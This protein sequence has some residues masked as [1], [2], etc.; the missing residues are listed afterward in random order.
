MTQATEKGSS[1]WLGVIPLG[2]QGFTLN[3]WEFRDAIS[4]RYN[5]PKPDLPANCPCGQR[6][7][8]THALNCKRGGFVIMRHNNV[9]DFEANLL[10]KV[11]NDVEVEPPLQPLSGEATTGLTGD[12]ARPDIR[13]KGF[14]RQCQNAFFDIRVTNANSSS[15]MTL[16]SKQLY[17]RH[18]NE[19]IRAYNDRIINVEQG[20][21]TPLIFSTNGGFGPECSLFHKHLAERLSEKTNDRYEKVI[22][23]IRCKLSFLILRACLTCI[24]GSRQ[25]K[26]PNETSVVEDFSFACNEANINHE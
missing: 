11:C 19:K 4:L 17:T 23:W 20:S 26:T 22:S 14:W 3:K 15:Q 25:F 5:K 7:D 1:S 2:E 18:E 21:F 12:E 24:R 9:L 8:I 10:R 13:A 16:S 6:F